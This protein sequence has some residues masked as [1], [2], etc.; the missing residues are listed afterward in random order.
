M[1]SVLDPTAVLMMVGAF[2]YILINFL[3]ITKDHHG[4]IH[5]EECIV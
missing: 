3:R 2:T 5:L 1:Q 4:L